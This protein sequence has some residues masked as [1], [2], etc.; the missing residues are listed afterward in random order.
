MSFEQI[1]HHATGLWEFDFMLRQLE[2]PQVS[3]DK[4]QVSI[5]GVN[6][7]QIML[8]LSD[9]PAELG[10]VGTK[11]SIGGHVSQCAGL[12]QGCPHDLH[13]ETPTPY[14]STKIRVDQLQTAP[15]QANS[16]GPDP[17]QPGVLLQQ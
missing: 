13:E 5:N 15:N 14:I 12:T 17:F 7:K 3:Y 6:M 16:P 10:Y 4:E 1:S 8:H 11:D 9:D 2:A